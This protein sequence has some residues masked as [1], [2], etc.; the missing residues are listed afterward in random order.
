MSAREVGVVV[1]LRAEAATL[2]AGHA[3]PGLVEKVGDLRVIVSGPGARQAGRAATTLLAEGVGALLS[4]GVAGGLEPTLQPGDLVLATGVA[5]ANGE[6]GVDARWHERLVRALEQAGLR[7]CPGK[8]WSHTGVVADVA[9]KRRLA[10]HGCVAVD[11]EAA[12]VAQV[13]T[14]AG[15]PFAAVKAVSDPLDRPLP[16]FALRLLRPDGGVRPT[17][18]AAVLVRG[19]RAWRALGRMRHDFAAARAGLRRAAA[20]VVSP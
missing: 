10:G 14:D 15:V 1:A 18:L 8:L 20:A 5:S 11:M 12:S 17:V 9:G 19:P 7:A 3:V 4:W 16:A 13:A 6:A 2:G